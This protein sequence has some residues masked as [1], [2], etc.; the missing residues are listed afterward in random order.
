[1][2]VDRAARDLARRGRYDVHMK[3]ADALV[4]LSRRQFCEGLASCIGVAAIAGCTAGQESGAGGVCD[5]QTIDCGPPA[6]FEAGTP[7][8]FASGLFFVVRDASG[9]YAVSAICT[10]EGGTINVT[11]SDYTCPRHAAVF[12]FD[13]NVV[14]G[15]ARLPL[16]HRAMCTL[17]NGNVGV[18]ASVTVPQAQRLDA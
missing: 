6:T 2:P 9:L 16:P 8:F 15:P 7:V 12:D 14:A 1:M 18:N 5:D 11:G 17:D 10:H 3:R 4:S 13:G